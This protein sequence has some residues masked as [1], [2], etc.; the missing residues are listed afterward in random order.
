MYS[1]ECGLAA[2]QTCELTD[3]HRNNF[4]GSNAFFFGRH[5]ARVQQL[6][7][8]SETAAGI[9]AV[10]VRRLVGDFDNEKVYE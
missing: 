2:S 6:T 5:T 9:V 1:A 10:N 7:N 4:Y 3:S 8:K